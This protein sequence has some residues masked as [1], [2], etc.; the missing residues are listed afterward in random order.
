MPGQG[1]ISL[2]GEVNAVDVL[3]A[4]QVLH[5]NRSLNTSQLEQGDL[6]PLLDGWPQPDGI[7]NLADALLILRLALGLVNFSY[8]A[9]QFNIGD[10]IGEGEAADDTIGEA[11]HETVWST[12]YAS[13]DSVASFNERLEA[14]DA[15]AYYENSAARDSVFNHAVSGA[16]MADFAYQ[17]QA[18][19]SYTSQLPGG[20]AGMVTVLL[21]NNDVCADTLAD[22]TDPLVFETHY[23]AGLDVLSASPATQSARINVSGIPAIYWLWNARRSNLLCRLVWP[24]VPC[25]NLLASAADDCASNASRNDPD[26]DY[27]G[28]GPNCLRR[29]TFHRTIRDSYNPIL[30]DVLDEYR[31]TGQLPN[32]YYTDIY[33]VR[34]ESVHVNGGD[35][36]H[37]SE[38]GHA[39][40]AEKEW[41]RAPWGSA[42]AQCAAQ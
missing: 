4:L 28:D 20:D 9:N 29:K 6:A 33:D 37:P 39:L 19:V 14:N 8:P 10:S 3:Q 34:F 21:G 22:M 41:C 5:G 18:V 2:D 12:G 40:L 11:H 32:A 27:P 38:A 42:D 25:Q 26:M 16:T 36:F 1:D 13:G 7:F 17:A 24:L 35:C 23:R 15:P 31:T 30:R